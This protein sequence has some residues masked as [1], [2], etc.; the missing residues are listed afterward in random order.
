MRRGSGRAKTLA[1][2]RLR[3]VFAGSGPDCETTPALGS[4][5]SPSSD[6]AATSGDRR[7]FRRGERMSV[8]P[9]H[10]GDAAGVRCGYGDGWRGR[11]RVVRPACRS[12][13]G[14]EGPAVRR[15]T[16][17]GPCR[18][19]SL[20]ATASFF[21]GASQSSPL[22]FRTI[23]FIAALASNVVESTPSAFPLSRPCAC[24]SCSTKTNTSR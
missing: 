15:C 14:P 20:S 11:R 1:V 4:A 16:S 19:R 3:R 21:R 5:S 23:N 6:L 9:L 22:S 24:T 7:Q 8:R 17:A 10:C 13:C 12:R 2:W 18:C